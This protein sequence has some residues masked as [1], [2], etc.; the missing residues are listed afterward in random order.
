[1]W[2]KIEENKLVVY[3]CFWVVFWALLAILSLIGAA[4][5]PPSAWLD[6]WTKW[7]A[8]VV[9]VVV[10]ARV[11]WSGAAALSRYVK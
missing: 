11:L 3:I 2:T 6:G 5:P 4:L 1:M 7:I 8:T 9:G 10:S